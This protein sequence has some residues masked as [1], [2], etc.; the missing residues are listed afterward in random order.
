MTDG[1][2]IAFAAAVFEGDDFLVLAL[3]DHFASDTNTRNR[4]ASVGYFVAVRMHKHIAKSHLLARLAL[5]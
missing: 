5:E 1:A 3:F 4:R 2:V